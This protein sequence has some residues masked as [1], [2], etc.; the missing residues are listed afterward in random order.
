MSAHIRLHAPQGIPGP[1]GPLGE[2][3]S[4]G[5]TGVRGPS[6]P[7]KLETVG[8][9]IAVAS[10]EDSDYPPPRGDILWLRV[11]EPVKPA[12]RRKPERYGSALERRFDKGRVYKSRRKALRQADRWRECWH[13]RL[14]RVVGR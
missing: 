5:P 8:Y 4:L 6:G 1:P 11:V 3:G 12:R 2:S 13:V 7:R 10:R 9:R 14:I